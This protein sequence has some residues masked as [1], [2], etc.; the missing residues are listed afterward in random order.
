MALTSD[1][2]TDFRED[3]ADTNN[4]FS[5]DAIQRLYT[6]AGSYAG[7]IVMGID[8]LLA[9]ATKLTKY[10]QNMSDEDQT[11]IFDR[12]LKLRAVKQAELKAGKTQ[13]RIV[14]MRSVPPEREEKPGDWYA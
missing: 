2:L 7:A 11:G 1:E 4:V 10:R 5:D 3:L 14:G 12:L 9:S 6:R 8:Q 13:V